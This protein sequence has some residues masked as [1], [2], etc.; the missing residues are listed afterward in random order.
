MD[1]EVELAVV[2]GK[3]VGSNIPVSSALSYVLGYT[4]AHDVSARD[5]L[6][7][8]H[9]NAGQWFLVVRRTGVSK[10]R[11]ILEKRRKREM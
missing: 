4:V 3:R 7:K 8:A 10:G 6:L 2:I 5:W 1:W 11:K 9:R